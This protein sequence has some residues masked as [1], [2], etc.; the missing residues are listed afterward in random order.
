LHGV[1]LANIRQLAFFAVFCVACFNTAAGRPVEALRAVK[2]TVLVL[3]GEPLSVPANRMTEQGLTAGL[4]REHPGDV[5]IFSEY[6]DFTRFPRAQYED[7]LVRYLRARYTTRKPDVVIA[8]EAATLQFATEQR[9]ELFP[10]VP[11]VFLNV[12]HREVE[13]KE[14]PP[15]VTGIWMAWDYQRTVELALQ[16]QPETREVVCVSGTG[17]QEQLWN[18]EARKVLERYATR[19]RTR[20][21]DKLPLQAVLDEVARLP[22]D[23]VVLYISMW[24]DG[25]GESVS[26]FEVARQLAEAS[27]VPVYGLSGPQLEQGLI[28]GA[29]QDFSETGR[30][31]AALAFRVLA[32]EKPPLLLPPD[33]GARPLLINWRALKK[34]HVSESRIPGEATVRYRDPSL[35]EQHPRLIVATAAV[36]GL[37]SLLIV[38][39][40]VQRSRLKRTEGSLRESEE[41]MSLAAEAANLGMWLWDVVRDK[42]W[43]T[44][45]GRALFGLAPD[46]YLDDAALIARVHPDDRAARAAAIRR[47][48]ETRGEYAMEY[49]A[50]LPDGTLR[51]IG[52]RGHCI[53]GGSSKGIRL[54]GVSMDVTAQKLAQEALRES[55]ARFR[56][57]ANTAPVMI[58]MSGTDKLCTFFNK[59]WLDFT[60]RPLEKELGN[61]WAEGIHSED[62]DR[63]LEVY[64]NSFD[65]RQPFTMEYRLRRSDG[66]YRWVLY[67][68]APRF[69]SDDTFVGFIGSCIDITERRQ[70]QD[71]FRLVVEAS[72]NGIVLFNAQGQIVLVNACAEKLFGY[73]RQEL[74]G[75]D[76]DLV[77][78][79][80]FRG[81]SLSHR[82]SFHTETAAQTVGAGLELFARHKD[83]T[84]FPVE[85]GS[86]LIEGP[87]G[88]LVLSVIVDISVRKQ[89]EAEARQHREELAHLSRV[90]IMGEM[91]GSLAHEL[92]QPLTGIVNNAS[93]GRRFIAKGRA[94]FPKLDSLFEAVVAD[95]RRA[96][97]IIRGIRS[98]VRK[99]EVVRGAV[100]LNDVIASVL[101]FVRSDALG[102]QCALVTEPDPRLPLVEA[103]QV[104]L[105][106][107]LLNLVVNAIEAMDETPAAERRVIV[108]SECEPGGRARVSVRDFGIGLP[109]EEPQRIFERF[110][111]TKREGMGMG[112]AIARSIIASHDGE[113]AAANVQG[114]GA[115]VHFSLPVIEEGQRRRRESS[116]LEGERE[117]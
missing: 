71:R 88:T 41:R 70:A 33:P 58:W 100:N 52:A 55:E 19:V 65:A 32:G 74:I 43:M 27:R 44:E 46:T 103:D 91:A 23:S 51:W 62:F 92:N 79:E 54:L 13:G 110:F 104:Q 109:A 83:G 93:A 116:Q 28:G 42:V 8:V 78:P 66:E 63:S 29:L 107:V 72:P 45:K 36:F 111:S 48:I 21:L 69:A 76:V 24:R 85:I 11:I 89:A 18:N 20:W 34:W 12:D 15:N 17:L 22:L 75:Q 35:W 4:S 7:G 10:G 53:N 30:E 60:G 3:Y 102:R 87:E 38:G 50:R 14:M 115:C 25:A 80:R 94:D 114:G 112:L 31:A 9:D 113:L 117:A 67:N 2:K 77:M 108:R 1:C 26:P 57:M 6:L 95:G 82:A 59:G 47:A 61:G 5:E 37:Q 105:Q 39:L 98:M 106:Q 97:E 56:S 96:G 84:E 64:L 99:G 73:E 68:G 90:A 86:S 40:I 101:Q 81:E 16:L 49:R